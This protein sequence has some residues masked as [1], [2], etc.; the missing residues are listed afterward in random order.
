MNFVSY[1]AY[2]FAALRSHRTNSGNAHAQTCIAIMW[3]GPIVQ[4]ETVEYTKEFSMEMELA[5]T[6]WS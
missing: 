2:L 3:V 1:G 6:E 4:R 5:N